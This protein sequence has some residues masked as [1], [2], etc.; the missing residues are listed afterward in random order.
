MTRVDETL[1]EGEHYLGRPADHTDKIITRRAELVKEIPDFCDKNLRLL[2]IGCGNGATLLL[3]SGEMRECIGVDIYEG[4]KKV[5]E[6]IKKERGITNSSVVIKNIEEQDLFEGN[7]AA[8]KFDRLICFE[9][10]EHFN[11]DRSIKRITK[12]L[13]PGALCAISVPN[14]WWIFE[15]HGARLPLLPWNRL[16]FFS[17]LPKP[18]HER[19]ANAR[20]YTRPRIIR[21]LE[22]NGFEVL[23]TKLITAPMD[24]LKEG[25]LKRFLV[26]HVFGNNTTSVPFLSTSIFVT[27]RVKSA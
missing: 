13:K 3:M 18:I 5:F 25:A 7:A 24:V 17:W 20:I 9:V 14:K 19:F 15:T 11:D 8:E 10:I 26:K 1:F 16:P 27:A 12:W 21:L 2:E 6:E 22:E 23:E 4:H